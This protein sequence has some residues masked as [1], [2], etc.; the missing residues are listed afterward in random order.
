MKGMKKN[1]DAGFLY[2]GM[3]VILWVGQD[4]AHAAKIA[5]IANTKHNFSATKPPALAGGQTRIVSATLESQICVF[6]HTPHAAEQVT[7]PLWNRKLS[8]A[9]YITYRSGSLDATALPGDS[10]GQ[11]TGISKL[12]LS[13]HDGTLAVGAVNVI[14]GALTDRDPKT[15]DIF[16][17]GAGAGGVMASS[18]G[19]ATGF[20]RYIGINLTNDHPISLT[21]DTNLALKDGEM[22]DPALSS[23]IGMRRIGV[24]PVLPLENDGAGNGQVQC[25]TCHDPHIRDSVRD[26]NIKFLRLNRFQRTPPTGAMFNRE[27]DIIC[28]ACHNK[29]GWVDSA[30][31]NPLVAGETYTSAAAATREF[32]PNMQ[33]WESAC[34]ACHDTHSVQGSRRL[35]REGTDGTAKLSAS[36]LMIKEGGRP[37][38]EETCFA[39]HSTGGGTLTA[40]GFLTEV[41]DIK[42]D[43]ALSRHMPITTDQQSN[44]ANSPTEV[45]NIGTGGAPQAGKD[46]LEGQTELANRHVECTDCHNPHRVIKNRRFNSDPFTPDTAGTHAHNE[47]DVLASPEGKHSNVASG[48]LRGIWGV[49]PVYTS[50]DFNAPVVNIGFVVKRGNP[51]INVPT[52]VFQP[53]VTREYQ[54]CLKCHSNYAYDNTPPMLDSFIGGTPAGT[55]GM[56]Q[57]TNQAREYNSP[58]NHAGEGISMGLDGGAGT[59][60]TNNGAEFNTNNHRSWHPAL[61]ETGRTAAVGGGGNRNADSRN[62]L[63]PFNL[64]VGTQTMYCTD[65]H[66]SNSANGTVVPDSNLGTENGRVWGPHGSENNFLLKGPW[67]GAATNGTGEG[68]PNHLCFKCHD[69]NQYANAFGFGGGGG[70]QDSGYSTPIAFCGSCGG[71]GLNNLHIYHAQVV[72]NFRCNLCHVAVPHGWKNKAFLV[73]LNDVGL[74]A[75]LAPGTQVRNGSGGGFGGFGGAGGYTQGPYY[76]RAALKVHNFASSGQWTPANCGSAGPPGNGQ[77]GVQWM[78]FGSE[79]CMNLP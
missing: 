2:F 10:L 69:Y 29:A 53:Y 41:P 23:E 12:C 9:T 11:P 22:R 17:S 15:A 73:N 27:G 51:S 39:C 75:G 47:A 44:G 52:D 74:E 64:A 77:T 76:N 70:T 5:D 49:E 32:P 28:L 50:N 61:R 4:S 38:I 57:Y 21:Y 14:N 20:T 24:K 62:W 71:N 16:M 45:H 46:F 42:S 40:Q 8:G 65:C 60:L 68:Q 30:H 72:Q 36:G 48:V 1:A 13:C 19:T 43:F 55:N 54:L 35:L 33:V 3:V 18:E 56:L 26:E 31:A 78:A 7:A 63:S 79:A 37:A 34:L 66:G 58:I 59:P 6:C 25:N 67:S